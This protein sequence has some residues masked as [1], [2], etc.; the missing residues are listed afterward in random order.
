MDWIEVEIVTWYTC[1]KRE[2]IFNKCR[3]P[4]R[5]RDKG[6]VQQEMEKRFGKLVS[7][8]GKN[9]KDLLEKS[10]NM[11]IQ[12]VDQNE[13]GIVDLGDVSTIAENVGNVMK[14]GV[15]TLKE[16]TDEKK[17]QF[18]LKVLQPI[19]IESLSDVD[20]IMSKF[21]RITERDKKH[22]KSG[23]CKESIGFVSDQEGL[24]I[25]NIF[26]DSLKVFGLSFYPDCN[27]D[28]YYVDPCDRELYIALD[29]Y[30]NYLKQVRVNELQMVAQDLGA[31]H[32]K[33]TYKEEKTS[34]SKKNK[35]IKAN[36]I[37]V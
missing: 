24:R 21:I 30:F 28:F 11:A 12:A 5:G 29:E 18:E 22:A 10:K 15:Q 20:F 13:D 34:F 23:V 26:R 1:L 2:M 35:N 27:N 16:A 19:F 17:R 36:L 32:F 25:V 4:E 9:A 7:N 14:K 8:V 31:K 33:V 37:Q 3:V 6:I